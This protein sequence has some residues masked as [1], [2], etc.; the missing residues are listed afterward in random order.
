M[1]HVDLK[2]VSTEAKMKRYPHDEDN[3]VCMYV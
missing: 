3:N 1:S 2:A